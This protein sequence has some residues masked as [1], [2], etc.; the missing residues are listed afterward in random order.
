[1]HQLFPN[2]SILVQIDTH[3]DLY[4]RRPMKHTDLFKSLVSKEVENFLT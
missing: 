1:M 2:K 4:S 3:K